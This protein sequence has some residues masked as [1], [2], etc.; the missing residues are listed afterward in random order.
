MLVG[1]F[2]ERGEVDEVAQ[3]HDGAV[4]PRVRSEDER[5]LRRREREDVVETI[6]GRK[7]DGEELGRRRRLETAR[8]VRDV[9][10]LDE[11][12]D[13]ARVERPLVRAGGEDLDVALL[14]EAGRDELALRPT[15]VRYDEVEVTVCAQR[16]IGVVRG[17][18]PGL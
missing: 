17:K 5:V 9:M 12:R 14:G 13:V 7:G 2:D 18:S 4:R 11:E 16:G 10:H 8:P 3:T 15:R 1:G 6:R